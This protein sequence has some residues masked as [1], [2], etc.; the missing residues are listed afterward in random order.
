MAASLAPALIEGLKIN[1]KEKLDM[2][3]EPL[4][5]MIQLAVLSFCPIGTKI[6]I[7]E[8]ILYLQRPTWSQGIWR[9]YGRDSK[10]DLYYLFHAIRRYYLWYKS[11]NN[12]FYT[13]ILNKAKTG[14]EK[15]IET[16]NKSEKTSLIHTLS[17]Y[18]NI[19]NLESKELFKASTTETINMD[20]VFCQIKD[21]YDEKILIILSNLLMI[22]DEEKTDSNIDEYYASLQH[23]LIPTHLCIQRWIRDKLTC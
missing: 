14:I 23:F 7:S 5:V 17:L 21:I 16:Y 20:S 13:Y 15:L 11:D 6:S 2:I 9:W 3:L 12:T 18:K 10:E 1:P 22:I 19:L 8:N 4:Q